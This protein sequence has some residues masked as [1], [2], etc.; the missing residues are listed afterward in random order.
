MYLLQ[1]VPYKGFRAQS[2]SYYRALPGEDSVARQLPYVFDV[3]TKERKRLNIGPY[4]DL[5]SGNWL[6]YGDSS[7]KLHMIIRERGYGSA[8]LL[9]A[10]AETGEVD[11][12]FSEVSDTYVDPGKS[13]S[14]YFPETD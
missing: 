3:K 5:I 8:T 6:W 1:H 7:K 14:E 4:D 2:Y 10:D 12:V 13:E 9:K 11:T